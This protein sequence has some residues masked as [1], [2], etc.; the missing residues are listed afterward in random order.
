MHEQRGI[1]PQLNRA[2]AFLLS[3]SH[4]HIDQTGVNAAFV[5]R[6]GAGEGKSP[7]TPELFLTQTEATCKADPAAK[8]EHWT[9]STTGC[10]CQTH[11][12]VAETLVGRGGGGGVGP[13]GPAGG[14]GSISQRCS[15]WPLASFHTSLLFQCKSA[16]TQVL[17]LKYRVNMEIKAA[18]VS[19]GQEG[20]QQGSK[21]PVV[22]P[23]HQRS[24]GWMQLASFDG[25]RLLKAASSAPS[26]LLSPKL[27]V[28]RKS[29]GEP[30]SVHRRR[31]RPRRPPPPLLGSLTPACRKQ[32]G[33]RL[34]C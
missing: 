16:A 23:P 19:C 3:V 14:A 8:Q 32:A 31:W 26:S 25:W 1:P 21:R 27:V 2:G 17:H 20:N 33:F 7:P 6:S 13:P 24:L 4:D 22:L 34:L 29:A 11:R 12:G 5:Q 28:Y 18:L 30:E 9:R 10:G 15:A